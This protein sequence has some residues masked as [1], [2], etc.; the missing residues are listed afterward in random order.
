VRVL[1][2]P[3]AD[4]AVLN[5]A[6]AGLRPT[7]GHTALHQALARAVALGRQ[8]AMGLPERRVIVT[9]SDGI[10]D[11][12]GGLSAEEVYATLGEG[13]IPI[14]AVGFSSVSDRARRAAGLNALGRFA[15]RSGGVFVD[16][17]RDDPSVAFA[18]M[19]TR[20]AEVYRVELRCPDC[21]LDGHR[22]RLEIDLRD[23]G[24]TLTAGTDLRLLPEPL[25]A[26]VVAPPPGPTSGAVPVA[27]DA[28]QPE[29]VATAVW[30]YLVGGAALLAALAGAWVFVRR[31]QGAPVPFI[32][33]ST[34][35]PPEVEDRGPWPPFDPT[36]AATPAAGTATG[37]AGAVSVL[38]PRVP[39]ATLRATFMTG[40]RRGQQV[41]LTLASR[42]VL[43][44]D[45]GCHLILADAEVSARH[46]EVE[47]LENGRV[48]LRDLGS[49]NGTRLNGIAIETVHP[50]RDGDVIGIGQIE[51]RVAF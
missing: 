32:D 21:P 44:R 1:V 25:A 36:S 24:V 3:T 26:P 9:L 6:I 17:G 41:T 45:P 39:R 19:R 35:M 38:A 37:G 48:V 10:D 22:Y 43:G 23:A 8:Q 7:D 51:L 5:S 28:P 46:A 47:A 27:P 18:A 42:A 33:G 13:P 50:L 34:P 12:P 31:R 11:A 29:P 16:G 40:P 15:R 2:A 4:A 14:Y 49:T 30:P 20:I